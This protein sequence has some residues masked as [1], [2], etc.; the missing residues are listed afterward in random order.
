[1]DINFIDMME[2]TPKL[3]TKRCKIIALAIRIFLQFSIYPIT[4]IVWYLEG[5]FI[6]VLTLLLGFI[7]IGIIRSKLRNDSIPVKQ[8]EY[9]YNDTGIATWYTAKQFC[10]P[11]EIKQ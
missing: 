4:L 9:N 11:E 2:P 6:A 8:R 7:V 3:L 5:W 10:Y 1:M